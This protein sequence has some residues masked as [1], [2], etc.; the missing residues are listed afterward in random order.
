MEYRTYKKEVSVLVLVLDTI[1]VRSELGGSP[2][3]S[4][5][6]VDLAPTSALSTLPL[7]RSPRVVFRKDRSRRRS[8][9]FS[10]C[11]APTL[12]LPPAS[13]DHHPCYLVSIEVEI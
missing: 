2:D 8:G 11:L 10:L 12:P 13:F 3:A 4:S 9:S 1:C 6:A 5:V 7:A